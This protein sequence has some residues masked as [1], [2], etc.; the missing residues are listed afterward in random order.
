[1][2]FGLCCESAELKMLLQKWSKREWRG[3]ITENEAKKD[4]K[5]E[6]VVIH[7]GVEED[8]RR[9]RMWTEKKM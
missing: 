4:E 2:L 3:G 6:R 8:R 5:S 9:T 7:N 1:M